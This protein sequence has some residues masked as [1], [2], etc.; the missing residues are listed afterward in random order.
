MCGVI[1][2]G[3]NRGKISKGIRGTVIRRQMGERAIG[4]GRI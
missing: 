1:V 4:Y 2:R 3:D